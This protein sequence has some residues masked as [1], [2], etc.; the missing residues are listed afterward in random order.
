MFPRFNIVSSMYV[1]DTTLYVSEKTMGDIEDK[2]PCKA[3]RI[4]NWYKANRMVINIEKMHTLILSTAQKSRHFSKHSLDRNMNGPAIKTV[5]EEK[6]SGVV[7]DNHLYWTSQ[8][9]KIYKMLAES[10]D[11]SGA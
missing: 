11:S 9:D 10:L 4:S 3:V 2:F 1:D 7:I 8:I 5:T 6:N